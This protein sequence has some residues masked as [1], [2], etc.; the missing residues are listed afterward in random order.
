CPLD[1]NAD[2]ARWRW[3]RP[4]LLHAINQCSAPCNLQVDKETYRQSIRRLRLLLDGK[5]SLVVKEL[6]REM[7]SAAKELQFEKAARLRD[8]LRSIQN[9]NLRG[10]LEKNAQPEVF[11]QDPKK[12]LRG[13]KKVLGLE[14]V[15]RSIHGI[16]IAHL[17]GN[18]TVG[19]LVTFIDG[20]PFKPGY[21]RY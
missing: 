12:G 15:P 8:E 9:L 1:I 4:C 16:D 17:A 2:D 18:E 14:T 5:K 21:R 7:Q 19:S 10:D 3:F 20:L 6:E 13:L 11:Y